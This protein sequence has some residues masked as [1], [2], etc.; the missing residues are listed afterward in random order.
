MAKT[1]GVEIMST[2]IQHNCPS[3][4]GSHDP[5]ACNIQRYYDRDVELILCEESR[6]CQYKRSYNKMMLCTCPAVTG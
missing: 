4:D 2:R 6:K 5:T 1:G 3:E